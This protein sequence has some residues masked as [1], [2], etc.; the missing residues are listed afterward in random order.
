MDSLDT[1]KKWQVAELFLAFILTTASILLLSMIGSQIKYFNGKPFFKQPGLW[2]SIGLM[3]MVFS[4]IFHTIGLWRDKSRL[5]KKNQTLLNE[6][7]V[8]VRSVEFLLWFMAYVLTVPWIG[9][10]PATIIL[11]LL[12]TY[13]LG[14]REKIY[15]TAILGTA[16]AIVVIF[17]SLLLVKIPGGV[18]YDFFPDA[19]R[20]F[21]IL[22][23]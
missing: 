2:T 16:V 8:W 21:L 15:Y 18:L 23:L 9:Y 7:W 22:N 14:Y 1:Q 5:S 11:G 19:I 20:N 13:R 12:L 6:L 17:K 4:G 10:L 3:G